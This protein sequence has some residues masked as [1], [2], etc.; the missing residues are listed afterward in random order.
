M[1]NNIKPAWLFCGVFLVT[2]LWIMEF[3]NRPRARL[4]VPDWSDDLSSSTREIVGQER[5]QGDRPGS[6]DPSARK[7]LLSQL[8]NLQE[9]NNPGLQNNLQPHR[10]SLLSDSSRR[11]LVDSGNRQLLA[12]E[13]D[14][15]SPEPVNRFRD[16][17]PLHAADRLYACMAD[18]CPPAFSDQ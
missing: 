4:A 16:N 13:Q 15:Y 3:D 11:L 12:Q 9:S 10:N 1:N 8:D 2:L 18:N 6:K 17:N 5:D 14:F 7:D